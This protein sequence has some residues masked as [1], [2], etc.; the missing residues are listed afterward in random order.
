LIFIKIIIKI[1]P[2]DF[3]NMYKLGSKWQQIKREYKSKFGIKAD[4]KN[5]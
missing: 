4:F 5:K 3:E 2:P 1:F